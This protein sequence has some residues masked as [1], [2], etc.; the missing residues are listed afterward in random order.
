LWTCS[1]S[2]RTLGNFLSV[3]MTTPSVAQ[4]PNAVRPLAT[5]FRAYSIWSNFPVLENVVR[6]K[7]Y[8]ESPMILSVDATL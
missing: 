4:M 6:E 1:A 7:L 8:A 5:A 3:A 2:T